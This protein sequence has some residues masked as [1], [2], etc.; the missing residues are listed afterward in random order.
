M[1]K[2]IRLA[3]EAVDVPLP[4]TE[5][6]RRHYEAAIAAGRGDED[7]AVVADVRTSDLPGEF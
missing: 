3:R 6:V 5:Q 1:H 7:A 2:D 4:L